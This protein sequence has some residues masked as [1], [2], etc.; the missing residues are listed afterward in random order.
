MDL[1]TYC[2]SMLKFG[3]EKKS[4]FST[5]TKFPVEGTFEM[6]SLHVS[7]FQPNYMTQFLS[8]FSGAASPDTHRPKYVLP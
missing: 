6:L 7:H 1:P 3:F 2:L 5:L 8:N 4:N